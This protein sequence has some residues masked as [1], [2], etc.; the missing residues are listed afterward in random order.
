VG[1]DAALLVGL[2]SEELTRI[3]G[4]ILTG[5]R[6]AF[7]QTFHEKREIFPPVLTDGFRV[8]EKIEKSPC[9][10]RH[11]PHNFLHA[12]ETKHCELRV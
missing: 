12:S 10:R 7:G 3:D 2:W 5:L 6:F 1:C 4:V 11:R 8:E 9:V